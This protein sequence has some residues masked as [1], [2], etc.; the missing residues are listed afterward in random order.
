MVR[1][2]RRKSIDE[3]IELIQ[4]EINSTQIQDLLGFEYKIGINIMVPAFIPHFF[5]SSHIDEI[6][7]DKPP[8]LQV[9]EPELSYLTKNLN[10]KTTYYFQL[11]YKASI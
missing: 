4:N 2:F 10:I 5:I 1:K 7:G 3:R 11:P 6:K 9:F 8:Y